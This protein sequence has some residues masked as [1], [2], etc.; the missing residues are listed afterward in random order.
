MLLL[1]TSDHGADDVL[2]Q[3]DLRGTDVIKD[4]PCTIE[5]IP[6]LGTAKSGDDGAI[7]LFAPPW[8]QCDFPI[9]TFNGR[10]ADK[11]GM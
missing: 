2:V 3:V 4:R 9:S 7:R 6:S 1:H 11:L 8:G 5:G 10:D